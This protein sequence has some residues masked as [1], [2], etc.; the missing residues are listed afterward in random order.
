MY[1][2]P[3]D[4]Q[5][6]PPVQMRTLANKILVAI[7]CVVSFVAGFYAHQSRQINACKAIGGK[8]VTVE[9]IAVCQK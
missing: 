1:M 8:L 2:Q 4:N 5:K 9:K 6:T 3:T 7:L